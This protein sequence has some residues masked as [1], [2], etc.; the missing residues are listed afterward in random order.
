MS[1]KHSYAKEYSEEWF[2]ME[3]RMLLRLPELAT[4]VEDCHEAHCRESR[5]L[6]VHHPPRCIR[7]VLGPLLEEQL[8]SATDP[9]LLRRALAFVA[10]LA[11]SSDPDVRRV[12]TDLIGAEG[13]GTDEWRRISRVT[14]PSTTRIL[15]DRRRSAA[16]SER[17]ALR[18]ASHRHGPWFWRQRWWW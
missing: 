12:A 15:T 3:D 2:A 4:Q 5:I 17:R 11:A 14:G 8:R 13:K 1:G 16:R 9:G 18:L 6:E 10:D 7:E